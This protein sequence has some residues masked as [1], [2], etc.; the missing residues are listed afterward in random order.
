MILLVLEG[1][2]QLAVVVTS[3]SDVRF[4]H[5]SPEKS[6]SADNVIRERLAC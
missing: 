4:L 6:K 5:E 3:L 1:V 2:G